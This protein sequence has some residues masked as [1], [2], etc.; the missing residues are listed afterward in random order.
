VGAEVAK[1]DLQKQ[2]AEKLSDA[3]ILLKAGSW[4]N[5]YYLAGYAV[6]LALKAC[7]AKSFK[8]ETIPDKDLVNA[9]YTH[10]FRNLAA[11]AGLS[12]DL[13]K[14]EKA[15]LAFSANWGLVNS[16]SP[17]ARYKSASE[18]DARDLI[19]AISDPK[20]GVLPWITTY[21]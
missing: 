1:A 20:N 13:Q 4:A 15:D 2:A 8:S 5:A 17:D 10:K 6:E 3:G 9:T 7:I 19:A 11:T 14:R 21:W 12:P 18:Q 16:W